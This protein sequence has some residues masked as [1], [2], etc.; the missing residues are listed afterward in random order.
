MST[1]IKVSSIASSVTPQDLTSFFAFCG[2]I[3]SVDYK[4]GSGEA[5]IAFEKSGAANTALLLNDTNLQGSKMKVETE[6]TEGQSTNGGTSSPVNGELRREDMPRT[7]ILI[8]MLARGYDISDTVLER[9]MNFDKKNGLSD[10]V[11]TTLKQFDEKF[12]VQD[13]VAKTDEAYRVTDTLRSWYKYVYGYFGQTLETP[14]GQKLSQVYKD[15]ANHIIATHEEAKK[16]QQQK[17]SSP[18]DGLTANAI[19]SGLSYVQAP[20]EKSE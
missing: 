7:A 13:R 8:D 16:K 20:A 4:E 2:K 17:K 11:K 1:T 3:Q 18:A 12:H 10:K 19:S 5:T 9:G 6:K 14:T 15:A